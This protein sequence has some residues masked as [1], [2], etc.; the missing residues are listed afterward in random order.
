MLFHDTSRPIHPGSLPQND[1][2][3]DDMACKKS[4]WFIRE[5]ADCNTL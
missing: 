4:R 2:T 1:T 5:S 3:D